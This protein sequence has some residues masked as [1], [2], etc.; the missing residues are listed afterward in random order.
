MAR[1]FRIGTRGSKMAMV[2]TN[3]IIEALKQV[4]PE[5]HFEA[6]VIKTTGDKFMG[7]LKKIGGKGAFV[8][9]IERAL[10]DG[11]VEMAMHSMKDVPGD[12]DLPEGLIIPAVLERHDIRD[13]V[14]CR[15]GETF[16]GLKEGAKIG[17]SAPRRASIINSAFPYLDVVPMRGAADTRVAKLDSG[18]VDALILAKSGLERIGYE[19]RI[20]E[21]FEPDMMCPAIGQGIVGIECRENDKESLELLAKINHKD[22]FTCL[23]AERTMLRAMQG[24]C[25][26]PIAG[27][28]QVTKG[29]NL[30]MIAMIAS[31]DGN[32]VLRAR[33]KYT[34]DKAEE[35]GAAIAELLFEQGARGILD[36]C[37]A[38]E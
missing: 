7:D 32:T 1:T 13:V 24:N 6:K 25:H 2:Q 37:Y 33:E 30:R 26:T 9:E 14:V 3:Q 17:T 27:F 38:A 22:T 10:L 34:Y 18:E 8:K 28:C 31:P 36:A 19:K 35:L 20:S 5:D 11:E 12:V 4:S 15:V 29:G 21:V 16:V 23:T